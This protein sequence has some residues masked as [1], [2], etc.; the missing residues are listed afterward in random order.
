MSRS[1]DF[2]YEYLIGFNN[3]QRTIK[4]IW[5]LRHFIWS[6]ACE[7]GV[8]FMI[9]KANPKLFEWRSSIV[10]PNGLGDTIFSL[11]ETN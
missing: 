11:T 2:F 7:F 10:F 1:D 3:T 6:L 8:L 9:F 5:I 4:T